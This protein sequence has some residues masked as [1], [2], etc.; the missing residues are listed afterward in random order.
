MANKGRRRACGTRFN[1]CTARISIGTGTSRPIRSWC[2]KTPRSRSGSRRRLP[3]VDRRI[4][5]WNCTTNGSAV[6]ISAGRRCLS[7]TVTSRAWQSS[8]NCCEEHLVHRGQHQRPLPQ[9]RH[10]WRRL[11]RALRHRRGRARVNCNWVEGLR[12]TPL[13]AWTT[14]GEKLDGVFHDYFLR[15]KP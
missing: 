15:V 8:R 6:C 11:A 9:R 13:R 14:Y 1:L 4:S 5:R 10:A 2:R 7:W 3:P 12:S